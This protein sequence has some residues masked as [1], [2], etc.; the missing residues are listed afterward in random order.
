MPLPAPQAELEALSLE[1]ETP[2]PLHKLTAHAVLQHRA[3]LPCIRFVPGV[4]R[5]LSPF[6]QMN[7]SSKREQQVGS[8]QLHESR[9]SLGFQ[10]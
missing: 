5:L 3:I 6:S 1:R 8:S 7:Q 10:Q 2:H 9:G 4:C